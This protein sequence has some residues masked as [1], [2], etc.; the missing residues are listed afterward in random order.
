MQSVRW[1]GLNPHRRNGYQE[2]HRGLENRYFNVLPELKTIDLVSK[3]ILPEKILPVM[4]LDVHHGFSAFRRCK[5]SMMPIMV[6][7]NHL[8]QNMNAS[9]IR[10]LSEPGRD[11][12]IETNPE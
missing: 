12:R 8:G 5:R 6:R 4:V 3:A 9:D 2:V 1:C 10:E 11:A 7:F